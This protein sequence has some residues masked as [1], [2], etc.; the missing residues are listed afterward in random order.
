MYLP[1][2]NKYLKVAP[3][4]YGGHADDVAPS[5]RASSERS[6]DRPSSA[7]PLSSAHTCR[8]PLLQRRISADLHRVLHPVQLDDAQRMV[9]AIQTLRSRVPYYFA[10]GSSLVAGFLRSSSPHLMGRSPK[11]LCSQTMKVACSLCTSTWA[12]ETC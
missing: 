1:V 10:P 6:C 2:T 7:L 3:A 11:L 8:H 9:S 5:L 12:K 4:R